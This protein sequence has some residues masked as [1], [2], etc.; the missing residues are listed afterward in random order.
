MAKG[1]VIIIM[2]SSS[3]EE[4]IGP[5]CSALKKFGVT[6]EKR[7]CSAHKT[8][9]KL[10]GLLED[11][12]STG[13]TI[14][15]IT[16]AGKSNA[17]SGIVDGNT[18]FPVITCPLQSEKFG[19]A[20]IYSSLRMPSGVASMVVLEP[21]N[22]ALAAAKILALSNIEVRK[23]ILSIQQEYK[24]KIELDDEKLRKTKD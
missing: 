5:I 10:L 24:R 19:G 12:E 14:V 16:V 9:Q 4:F 15:Y 11:Y 21:D 13:D 6:Y 7:V 22:A 23:K 17:L 18:Q 3:D 20:D 8:P 1:K 2:G